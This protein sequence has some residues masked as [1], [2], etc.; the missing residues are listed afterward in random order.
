[1]NKTM[2]FI[3]IICILLA[4]GCSSE[5]TMSEDSEI[6]D[7]TQQSIDTAVSGAPVMFVNCGISESLNSDTPVNE[8]NPE[9][10][11]ALVCLGKS[12]LDG[13]KPAKAI[14]YLSNAGQVKY[15]IKNLEDVGCVIK[16]EYGDV[17]QI[18]EEAQKK[19]A[20]KF[21]ECP[22][23]I[24]SFISQATID[25]NTAPGSFAFGVYFM[26]AFESMTSE[27][28]CTGSLIEM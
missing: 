8:I 1:M 23:D 15:E 20:N 18:P 28:K 25:P 16:A 5:N 6:G 12:L 3:S 4:S 17:E 7:S 11:N 26:T 19:Y 9:L 2:L 13:C 14:L 10:D 27:T 21:F 24:D 22:V